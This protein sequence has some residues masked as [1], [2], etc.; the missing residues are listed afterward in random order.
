[1]AYIGY[2]MFKAQQ[3]TAT[4]TLPALLEYRHPISHKLRGKQAACDTR[5]QMPVSAIPTHSR[6]KFRA[7]RRMN[8][9]DVGY[10]A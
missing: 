4:L 10:V 5:Q 3:S 7:N 2:M 1:M 8:M 6:H 9:R